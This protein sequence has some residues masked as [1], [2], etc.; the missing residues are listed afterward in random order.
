MATDQQDTQNAI[1]REILIGIRMTAQLT[2]TQLAQKLGLP[3]SYVSKYEA[4]QRKLTLIEVRDISR[5]C[6]VDLKYFVELFECE[7]KVSEGL[8]GS[9]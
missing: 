5:C 4:G 2:Q 7:L 3:Q 1:Q 6:G 9:V 8:H